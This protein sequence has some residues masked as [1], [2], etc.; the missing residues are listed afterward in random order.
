MPAANA[1]LEVATLTTD[2]GALPDV[3]LLMRYNGQLLPPEVAAEL[4]R[5]Q[6]VAFGTN[7]NGIARLANIPAGVYEFWPYRSEAEAS[8]LLAS[9]SALSAPIVVNVVT[10][11][12]KAT[13]RFQRK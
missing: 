6:G 1:S 3:S 7:E 2:G 9:A 11:E 8:A 5:Q 10:G 4:Q 13:V 12:N